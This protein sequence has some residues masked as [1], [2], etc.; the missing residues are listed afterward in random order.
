MFLFSLHILPV[1][2]WAV[3]D[4]HWLVLTPHW[5][6]W[7]H[8]RSSLR[9]VDEVTGL[10]SPEILDQPSKCSAFQGSA[11]LY[12]INAVLKQLL[13]RKFCVCIN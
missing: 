4:W 8:S 2:V 1:Y 12:V 10:L 9:V 5:F 7:E 3:S 13:S 11:F 6:P